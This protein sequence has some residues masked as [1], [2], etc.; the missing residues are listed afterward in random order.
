M[1]KKLKLGMNQPITRRDFISGAAVSISGS[2]IWPYAE[3]AN[4]IQGT[5]TLVKN[6]PPIRDGMRGSHEGS[7]EIAHKL[8]DGVRWNNPKDS[9]ERY[10]LVVVGG[11]L[12]YAYGHDP[13]S[14]QVAWMLDELPPERSPWIAARKPYGRIAIANSD[15]TAD[16][17]TEGAFNAAQ[18]AVDALLDT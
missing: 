2:L 13:E 7:Y 10:D 11:G 14:G 6:Y 5:E 8:R 3:A 1:V 18:I 17:M 9:G 12:G 15:A 16:A 4:P